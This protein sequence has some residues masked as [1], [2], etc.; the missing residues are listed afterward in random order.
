MWLAGATLGVMAATG[1]AHGA[2]YP[3][4]VLWLGAGMPVIRVLLFDPIDGLILDRDKLILSAWKHP[5]TIA[6]PDILAVRFAGRSDTAAASI[7]LTD[8]EVVDINP[9]DLPPAQQWRD[10][11]KRFGIR[12]QTAA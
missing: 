6:L 10:L 7:V 1:L 9:R 12:T 5:R 4:W 3:L 8:G 2:P 11:L